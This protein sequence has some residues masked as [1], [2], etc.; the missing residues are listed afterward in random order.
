VQQEASVCQR[1]CR[2]PFHVLPR[3]LS[4]MG[5]EGKPMIYCELCGGKIRVSPTMKPL[6]HEFQID[7]WAF[8]PDCKIKLIGGINGKDR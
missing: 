7:G 4:S 3:L 5:R 2:R 6:E 1:C 8:C